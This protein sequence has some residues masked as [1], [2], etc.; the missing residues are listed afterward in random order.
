MKNHEISEVTWKGLIQWQGSEAQE[1]VLQDI[2]E[3]IHLKVGYRAMYDKRKEYFA[4]FDYPTFKDNV[5]QE[6]RT[7]KALHTKEVRDCQGVQATS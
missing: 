5:R 4:Y 7:K 1:Y 3:G 2:E 6:V